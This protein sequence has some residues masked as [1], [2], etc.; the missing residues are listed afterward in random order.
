MNIL[1]SVSHIPPSSS[2]ANKPR[3]KKTETRLFPARA[4]PNESRKDRSKTSSPLLHLLLD[5]C[6]ILGER[7]GGER[8]RAR[9]F[10]LR[11]DRG[12]ER[13][14]GRMIGGIGAKE[15]RSVERKDGAPRGASIKGADRKKIGRIR[16]GGIQ[17]ASVRITEW[18]CPTFA[19]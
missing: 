19:Q 8:Q 4:S 2:Y 12:A 17:S 9:K 3:R 1:Q 5:E 10:D 11:I 13:D 14:S 7:K 18:L 16:Y 6:K 15:E